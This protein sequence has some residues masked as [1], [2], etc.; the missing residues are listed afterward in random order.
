MNK[1]EIKKLKILFWDYKWESV[2]KNLDSPLVISRI[3]ELGNPEQFE[4]LSGFLGH[5]KIYRFLKEKG[6]KL[7][8]KKSFNFWKIY[9]AQK[10]NSK[11]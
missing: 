10:F 3:L 4:I 7:L 11:T 6:K 8:S 2:E 1:K 5:E 9:Y